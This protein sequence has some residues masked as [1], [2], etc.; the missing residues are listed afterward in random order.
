MGVA[1]RGIDI[2]TIVYRMPDHIGRS[3]AFEGGIGGFDLSSGRAW[4]LKI[5]PDLRHKKPQNFL[6]Y[7]ACMIQLMCMLSECNWKPGD[8]FLSVGDNISALRWIRKSNFNPEAKSEHATHLALAR[9]V[10]MR[11]ADLRVTQFSQWLPGI[12][13]V[14]ADALSR[15]HTMSDSDLTNF[16]VHSYPSQTPHGFQI[17]AL[18]PSVSCWALYWLR[19]NNVTKESPPEPLARE[20]HGG[21]DGL[22]SYTSVS[23]TMMCSSDS[24]PN[25]N[26]TSCS[27]PSPK[28]PET[29]N[30]QCPLKDMI[31]WLREHAAPPSM[32]FARPSSSPVGTTP[33]RIRTANLRSFYN[34]SSKGTGTTTR[35]SNPKKRFHSE[36]SRN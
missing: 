35:P 12:D 36:S 4:R 3:D 30:G 17:K 11:L 7:L 22:I 18:P 9:H 24:S 16:I 32:Q 13:N 34:G 19:H 10:T 21:D 14:V 8:C 20:T 15:E 26:D 28:R 2:N 1:K 29:T 33:G 23:C 6:E 5:P 27:A 25:M 31:S